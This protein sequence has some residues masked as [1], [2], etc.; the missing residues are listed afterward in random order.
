[1]VDVPMNDRSQVY[2]KVINNLLHT[3]YLKNYLKFFMR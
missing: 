1:M 2:S 3:M